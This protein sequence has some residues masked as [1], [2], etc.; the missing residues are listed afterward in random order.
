M[1]RLVLHVG[2]PK[3]GST[4]LQEFLSANRD[5]LSRFGLRWCESLRGP[6]HVQLAVAFTDQM[7]HLTSTVGVRNKRDQLRL[8]D[9][10]ARRLGAEL[11]CGERVLVSTEH[12][13]AALRSPAEVHALAAFLRDIADEVSVLAVLRRND[14]WLPSS[15]AEAVLND[16]R[17]EF[18]AEFVHF[19]ASL[20]D[21]HGFL[22][23]WQ[24]A[25]GA[26]AVRLLPMLESDKRDPSAVPLRLLA[27]LGV[28]AQ[29]GGWRRPAE[30]AHPAL[31]A[32]GTEMLRAMTPLLPSGGLRP[33]RARMRVR[34]AIAE[35]CPGP[36]VALTPS[37]A[38]EL[39]RLGWRKSGIEAV[40]A[41][42]GADWSAWRDQPDA[43]VRPLPV[44]GEQAVEDLLSELRGNRVVRERS[45]MST[46]RLRRMAV[47]L[48]RR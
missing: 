5:A 18:D 26:D 20:L 23:R 19:R 47:R 13:S 46:E 1:G 37:A 10:V 29:D 12:L 14:Y 11:R 24:D 40:P 4:S 25:F 2:L 27:E 9:R 30:L 3:T 41:A 31:S 36:P 45:G 34:T 39:D 21:H 16:K 15:Y 33:G 43:D 28:P 22:A 35:R 42:V 32:L 17:R 6:N 8:R 44:V 38:A 7:S 48:A